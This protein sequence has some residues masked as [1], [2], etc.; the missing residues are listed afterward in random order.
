MHTFI[1]NHPRLLIAAAAGLVT[2]FVSPGHWP[3]VSRLLVAWNAA[4]VLF[5]VLI[6]RW[7]TSLSPEQICR[8]FDEEDESTT[9][10]SAIV[11][12][13][14]VLSLAAIIAMLATVKQVAGGARV[15]HTAL[16][17][18]TLVSSWLL[19]PTVFTSQY[20]Q[21]FY[22]APD[23]RRPLQFPATEAPVFW[24][25]AYFAFTISCACQTSDVSTTGAAV[26]RIVLAQTLVA[27]LFN[28]AILGF[29]INVGAG[30]VG[31]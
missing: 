6:F 13:A 14:A 17:A 20:A 19:V 16:A 23:R 10:I 21:V 9:A 11:V 1:R 29:A 12:T 24:D 25:F 5:L 3:A 4:V 7:M 28:A 18:V 2:F 8:R 22:S 26:R 31:G 27:F 30:L 15:A